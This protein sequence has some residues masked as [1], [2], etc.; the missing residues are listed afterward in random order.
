ML[1]HLASETCI[2]RQAGRHTCMHTHIHTMCVCVCVCVCSLVFTSNKKS[3]RAD[4][5][6]QLTV[7]GKFTTTN[8]WFALVIVCVCLYMR[9][10]HS[11]LWMCQCACDTY[12][13]GVFVS[14]SVCACM[15]LHTCIFNFGEEYIDHVLYCYTSSRIKGAEHC[16]ACFCCCFS[17]PKYLVVLTYTSSIFKFCL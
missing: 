12:M 9:A 2:N 5:L 17:S 8:S 3:H 16:Q 1:Y 10:L 13:L 11:D 6:A 14:V 15:L 7:L 4:L